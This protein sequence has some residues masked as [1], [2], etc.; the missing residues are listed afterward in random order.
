MEI[1]IKTKGIHPKQSHISV[2][3]SGTEGRA[4][5]SVYR[6]G[7]KTENHVGAN[8]FAVKNS[9]EI[10][11]VSKTMNRFQIIIPNN[12]NTLQLQNKLQTIK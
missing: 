11:R 1:H 4:N 6:D 7:L 5:V 2:D 9:T 8:V 12:E 10:Q 3:L